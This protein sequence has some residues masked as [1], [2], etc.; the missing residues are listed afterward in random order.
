V[1]KSRKR[2]NFELNLKKQTQFANGQNERKY[3]FKRALWRFYALKAA[4][5]QSQ[6]KANQSQLYLAPRFIWGLKDR[7]EK[8]NPISGRMNWRKVLCERIL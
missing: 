7:F 5:K 2:R 3:L 1:K 4:K 8:T 6:F